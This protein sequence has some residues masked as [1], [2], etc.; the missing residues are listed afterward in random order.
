MTFSI[1]SDLKHGSKKF[2]RKQAIERVKENIN[3]QQKSISDYSKDDLKT[4]ILNEE[5]KI[6]KGAGIKGVLVAAGA[7]FGI[8]FI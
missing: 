5:R 8:T 6:L 4:F 1:F 2:I 3:Y 7:I